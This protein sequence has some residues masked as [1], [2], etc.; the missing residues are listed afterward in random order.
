MNNII[1]NIE[2]PITKSLSSM[3]FSQSN[4]MMFFTHKNK[5][6]IY[7]D[8]STYSP[9][10]SREL[11]FNVSLKEWIDLKGVA[12]ACK[13]TNT[14]TGPINKIS[15][16]N[17]MFS[18]LTIK[19]NNNVVE[20]IQNYGRFCN[21]LQ[22]YESDEQARENTVLNGGGNITNREVEVT[23]A[24]NV[25]LTAAG[26]GATRNVYIKLRSGFLE[27]SNLLPGMYINNMEISLL[28]DSGDACFL[29]AGGDAAG[30]LVTS[31]DFQITDARIEVSTYEIDQTLQNRFDD[32]IKDGDSL[33][34]SYK[35]Y[36]H[37][38][39][40]MANASGSHLFNINSYNIH[41]INISFYR[42]RAGALRGERSNNTFYI[43]DNDP[44]L[45]IVLNV[46]G[47]TIDEINSVSESFY[48]SNKRV[49][50]KKLNTT[51]T[52]YNKNKF[53]CNFDLKKSVEGEP[54]MEIQDYSGYE[55]VNTGAI[56]VNT[57][58]SAAL[59]PTEIYVLIEMI[60]VLDLRNI[61]VTVWK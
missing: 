38:S 2:T 13:I 40:A 43:Q 25:F 52:E 5:R 17:S 32:I 31:T 23:A 19:I 47:T 30:A 29:R 1:R 35:Q 61:G 12:L 45:K 18:R 11:K 3:D 27:T 33:P 20:E 34:I 44:N 6:K 8:A 54:N 56:L 42:P 59:P 37:Y 39:Q 48:T 50:E 7:S 60:S 41:N 57:T 55:M 16:L 51:Y 58:A 49:S 28:L 10:G 26:V 21:L 14:G 24:S 9:N 15:D 4:N 53:L 22:L 46:G 36:S